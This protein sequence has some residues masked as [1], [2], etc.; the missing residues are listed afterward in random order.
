ML[1][2]Q[3]NLN[4]T[5]IAVPVFQV[6]QNL[7]LHSFLMLPMQRVTRLPLLVNA[8]KARLHSDSPQFAVARCRFFIDAYLASP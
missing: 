3:T 1:L 4:L 6:C 5:H 7:S 2:R 8:L